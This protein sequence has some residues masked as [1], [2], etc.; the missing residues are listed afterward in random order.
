M[1]GANTCTDITNLYGKRLQFILQFSW[2]LLQ[3]L[4]EHNFILIRPEKI[5]LFRRIDTIVCSYVLL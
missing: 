1:V 3:T 5:E 2:V 4:K